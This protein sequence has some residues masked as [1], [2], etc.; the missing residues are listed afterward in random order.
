MGK[1]DQITTLPFAG[2]AAA[3]RKIATLAHAQ[4]FAKTLDRELSVR[5]IDKREPHQLPSLAK[6]RG[7]LQNIAILAKHIILSAQA[8]QLCNN[9]LIGVR[10]WLAVA[11]ITAVTDSAF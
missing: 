9:I 10:I 5:L 7:L 4:N 2:T 8:F 11:A 6:N 1:H 3:I